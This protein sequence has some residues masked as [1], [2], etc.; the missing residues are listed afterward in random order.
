MGYGYIKTN[1]NAMKFDCVKDK[2]KII[3]NHY[4][5]RR[6]NLNRI[7]NKLPIGQFNMTISSVSIYLNISRSK[8]QRLINEFLDK[9]IIKL[10]SKGSLKS[11]DASIYEYI[12]SDTE[13]NTVDDTK[14]ISDINDFIDIDNTKFD[15]SN[16]KSKKENLNI[17]LNNKDL[18]VRIIDYLNKKTG[19]SFKATTIKTINCIKARLNEGFVE[20]DFYRVIDIKSSQWLDNDMCKFL[21]PETLFSNKFE[22]YLNEGVLVHKETQ[23]DI[24]NIDVWDIEF[25]Y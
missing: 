12:T 8:A 19:K 6:E 25:D 15:T 2:D 5:M 22:G 13:D 10:I 7:Q 14:N 24:D 3:F 23:D 20:E 16:G 11:K 21:R 4:I 18:Y 9:N 17:K 1:I